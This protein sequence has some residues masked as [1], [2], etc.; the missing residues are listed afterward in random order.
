MRRVVVLAALST[1][2]G[3]AMLLLAAVAVS[4]RT[5]AGWFEP[6]RE[7]ITVSEAAVIQS[8]AV[9]FTMLQAGADPN[10]PSRV[11]RDFVDADDDLVVLPLEAAVMGGELAVVQLLEARGARRDAAMTEHLIE[12]AERRGA[13]D[14][15]EHLR[16][17]P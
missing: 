9:L 3:A 6:P 13:E 12:I 16:E 14:I 15:V 1:P 11:R 17:H 2:I 4:E 7:P 10:V 8:R 5:S